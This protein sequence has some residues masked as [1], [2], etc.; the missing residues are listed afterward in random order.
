MGTLK[1]QAPEAVEQLQRANSDLFRNS[2][3]TNTDYKDTKFT[4]NPIRQRLFE[5]FLSGGKYSVVQL[6]VAF[7]IP[8]PRSHIRYIRNAG[9]PIFDNWVITRFSRYKVY[10]LKIEK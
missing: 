5:L 6:V 2:I 3:S 1:K 10:Y 7:H 4:D 8:D 9:I